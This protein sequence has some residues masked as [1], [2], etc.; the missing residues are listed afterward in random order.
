VIFHDD[1]NGKPLEPYEE[2]FIEVPEEYQGAIMEMLGSRQGQMTNLVHGDNGIVAMT[3]KVPTRGL[4][5]F[6]SEALTATRGT[7]VMNTLLAGYEPLSGEIRQRDRGS[8]VAWEDGDAITYGLRNA[9][10]R[11][12]LFIESATPVYEG[13]VVG[14]HARPDDLDVN[15]CKTKMLSA[16]R[17]RSSD[18]DT[19]RLPP[20][21]QMSLDDCIEYIADDELVEVTPL[22]IRIRKKYLKRDERQ[23]MSSSRAK[24]LRDA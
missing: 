15:V 4:L 7:V 13:M 2:V 17:T 6:R 24:A 5:G 12:T 20:I 19:S 11:G 18:H 9:W 16:V 21:R 1:E 8:L 14:E 10:E 22:N 3:Y 23:K